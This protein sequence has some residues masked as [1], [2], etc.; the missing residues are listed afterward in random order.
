M[1]DAGLILE[2]GGMRG[3]YTAGV[4]D[5]FLDQGLW[6]SHVYG[7]SAGACHACSYLSG[8]RGRAFR[9]GTNYLRDKRYCSFHSLITTGDMFGV[10]MCY[11]LIPNQL[12]PYDYE[13]FDRY[14][15][16]FHAVITNCVTGQAEYPRLRDMHTDIQAVRASSSL[17]LISRMVEFRGQRYLDGGI[18]DSIPLARSVRDGNRKN[19]VI[20]TRAQGYRKQPNK[21]MAA[22]RMEYRRYP[23]LVE[24]L[25]TRHTRYNE[26]VELVARQEAE[27]AAF[28]L[29]P[30]TPPN[31]GR[32]EKDLGKLKALYQQGYDKAK[33]ALPALLDFLQ[34]K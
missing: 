7:V 8:Q 26:A 14:E 2:G 3:I 33:Q 29:R 13:A 9:V 21:A 34:A 24:A 10:E 32:V 25:A 23:H 5:L 19:V 11:D 15:G 27:G 4:L 18:A 30:Q 22:I 12:D 6:F 28:V 1:W 17:P 31:I 20:L 16:D